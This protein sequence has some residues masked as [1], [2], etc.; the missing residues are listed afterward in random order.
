MVAERI[1][2]ASRS[3]RRVQLL[4]ELGVEPL[5][6]PADVDETPRINE[7]PV[8]YVRRVAIDKA[9][10]VAQRHADATVI[11]A[12]TTVDVDGRILGQP[13]DINE[14]RLMLRSLSART[15]RVHTA[16]VVITSESET[17][18][19]VTSLV[20]FQPLDDETLEWYLATGESMGKAGA[21]A[22]QGQG[23]VLVERVQGSMSNVVGLPL[24]STARLLGLRAPSDPAR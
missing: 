21:Y 7:D 19:V 11:A 23:S 16:V 1:V 24:A 17:S 20:S 9:R 4:A 12:D 15:H 5:V 6:D 2:L 10:R 8:A 14:A 3:P 18:D 13:A 22:V